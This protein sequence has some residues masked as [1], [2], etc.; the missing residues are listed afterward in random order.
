M[1]AEV[2]RDTAQ[3]LVACGGFG[4]TADVAADELHGVAPVGTPQAMAQLALRGA[5]VDD[6]YEVSGDDDA[7]LAFLLGVLG[8]EGLFD[9]L[10]GDIVL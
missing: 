8:D 3:E 7:V 6:G 2:G 10:H 9:D 1:T 4:H 5:A